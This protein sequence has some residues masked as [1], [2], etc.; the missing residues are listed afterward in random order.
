MSALALH[1]ILIIKRFGFGIRSARSAIASSS[2]PARPLQVSAAMVEGV[3]LW[4]AA[5][6][7]LQAT[8]ILASTLI[9]IMKENDEAPN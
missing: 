5:A 3:F 2:C 8:E 1:Q 6:A 4:P 7:Q 9:K